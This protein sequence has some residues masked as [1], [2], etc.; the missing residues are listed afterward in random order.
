M[1]EI[2]YQS[3]QAELCWILTNLLSD[4]AR[5]ISG[6]SWPPTFEHTIIELRRKCK[7][8]VF[9]GE[10]KSCIY[11]LQ[12]FKIGKLFFQHDLEYGTVC[13]DHALGAQDANVLHR[14]LW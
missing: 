2:L 14:L 11:S 4:Y 12:L 3:Q 1:V 7:F 13:F 9:I 8:Q 10:F 5:T 6:T